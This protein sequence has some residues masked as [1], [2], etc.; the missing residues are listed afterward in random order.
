[1]TIQQRFT[2][3]LSTMLIAGLCVTPEMLCAQQSSQAATPQSQSNGQQQPTNTQTTPDANSQD[4]PQ[5][6]PAA[7]QN[8]GTTI[9]PSQGPLQPVTTYP[10]ASQQQQSEPQ[11][12]SPTPQA[13]TTTTTTTEQAPD[14]P[15]PKKPQEPAGAANAEKVPTAG[16]AA[17]KPAGVAIAPAKQ[18][19]TRSLLLKIGAIAAAGVAAGTVYA[20]SRGTSST[21]PTNG[22]AGATQ[23]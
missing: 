11:N 5:Q 9:D 13:N 6:Q 10:D 19:Q 22:V 20:L 7:Q 1:M 14:A 8:R 4:Q 17:S 15:Q 21:P 3:I 2:K 16:G 23:K 18:H 12:A